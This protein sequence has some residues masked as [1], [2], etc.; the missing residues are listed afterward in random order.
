MGRGGRGLHLA[1]TVTAVFLIAG[2]PLAG[3][4]EEGSATEGAIF[5]LLPVSAK[6]VSMGRAMTALAGPES[7]WWNPAGLAELTEDHF[8]LFRGEDLSGDA[9]AASLIFARAGLGTMAVAYQLLDIGDQEFRLEDGSPDGTLASRRHLGVISFASR[10]WSRINLGLNLKVVQ[11][12]ETCRGP[13]VRFGSGVTATTFAVDAGAQITRV[14]GLPLRLGATLAH[15]GGDVKFENEE[16]ADPLPT[17]IRFAAAYELLEQW[18]ETDELRLWLTAE[19]EDSWHGG[20]D[21]ATYFG[22]ELQVGADEFLFS[23]RAGYVRNSDTQVDGAA[24]GMGLRYESFDLAI[25]KSLKESRLV[26]QEPIHI[27]FGFIF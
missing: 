9:T 3:Q 21:P 24:V 18:A 12:R 8:H 25:A 26:D 16:Q 22:L 4:G 20:G 1:L 23:P 15:A 11:A 17:R 2:T 19:V 6:A 7:M 14:S 13:C 27:S 10:F 5:L